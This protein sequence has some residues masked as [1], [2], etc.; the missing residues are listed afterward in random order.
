MVEKSVQNTVFT[1]LSQGE[2]QISYFIIQI[3]NTVFKF[4]SQGVGSLPDGEE[5]AGGQG[6]GGH[7]GLLG[8]RGLDG[9]R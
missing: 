5:Q 8:L 3:Q 7:E 2:I 9:E 1:F 4:L 6:G